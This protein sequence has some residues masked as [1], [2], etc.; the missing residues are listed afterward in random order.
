MKQRINDTI[1]NNFGIIVLIL[2]IILYIIL[3]SAFIFSIASAVWNEE[4][5]YPPRKDFPRV[6]HT[7]RWK[8]TICFKCHKN[9]PRP[10][11]GYIIEEF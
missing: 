8:D 7:V 1:H 2:Y 4:V 5:K 6:Y 9:M 3:T 11:N 10:K